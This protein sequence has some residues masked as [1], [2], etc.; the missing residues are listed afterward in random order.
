VPLLC[1]VPTPLRAARVARRLCDAQGGVLFGRQVA[2]PS[3]LVPGLLAEAGERRPLL[4]PLAERLLALEA[5]RAAGALGGEIDPAGGLARSLLATVAEMR[6]GEVTA[7][8]AGAAAEGLEPRPA[9]RLRSL[10]GVLTRYERR[11]EDLGVLDAA[12]GERAAA[13]ALRRG[14]ASAETR[15]LDLLVVEGFHAAAPPTFDL[16]SALAERAAR[17]EVRIPYLPQRPDLC[18]PAESLL[19]RVE[20]MH[21]IAG[22]GVVEVTFPE[23]EA[24]RAPRLSGLL[25][26][27][28]GGGGAQAAGEGTVRAVGGGGEEGEAQAAARLASELLERGL[29]PE[30]L[31]LLAPSPSRAAGPLRR[32]FAERGVPL[33]AGAA[34]RL[35][36]SPPVRAVLLALAAAPRPTREAAEAL[37]SSTYL[38]PVRSAARIAHLL[39]RAGALD[40]RIDPEAALRE[41]AARLTLPSVA[42][43]RAGLLGAAD[44]LA[45]LSAGIRPLAAPGTG[46]EM[47][48]RLR[49]FLAAAGVR[50]R[51]A[52]AEA[53]VARRDLAALTRLEELADS[54]SEALALL[55]RGSERLPPGEWRALVELA[56]GGSG[57]PANPEPAAGAVELWPLSEAPG[58]SAR[59]VIA[60]G[61]ARGD[62]PPPPAPEAWLRDPERGAVNR[63][64]RRAALA[65][66]P[67]RRAESAYLAFSAMAAAREHLAFT[68][69]AAGQADRPAP[70][71]AEALLAAGAEAPE[72]PGDPSLGRAGTAGEALRAAA[73]LAR[74]GRGGE[75]AGALQAAGL[76]AR[77]ASAA[78]RGRIE[79]ERRE[80][81]LGRAPAP[82]AGGIPAE[83]IPELRAALPEEWTPSQLE[84]FA[85][86]PF[87]L[88][89]GEVVGLPEPQAAGLDIDPRDEGRLLH[90]VLERVLA[91]RLARG[92]GPLAGTAEEREEARAA[93]AEVFARFEAEGRVGAPVLWPARRSAL[94]ARLER[95]LAAE[96]RSA[97]GL[98]PRLL[99]HRFGGA[100]GRP[101]LVLRDGDEEVRL[102]GR[103]DRV[104][105]DGERLLVIDYKNGRDPRAA[106]AQL[107]EEALGVTSFQAPAYVMAAA[108]ELPGRRELAASFLLLRPAERTRPAVFG[109]G[110]GFLVAEPVRRAED[111]AAGGSSFADAVVALVRKARG[112][113]F[114]IASRDCSRCGFGAVC[115]FPGAAEG[116]P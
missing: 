91:A 24:G 21:G 87:Q 67:A 50:R 92:Q 84:T 1:L 37:A 11:L 12:A 106:A 34:D 35:A 90:A 100:S 8:A 96:A 13:Q 46:R 26:A 98:A 99:E 116:P 16:L 36:A 39:D 32:A 17:T 108:R 63:L 28:A 54:L 77:A 48:A 38:G 75:A 81:L 10:A 115:R 97:D 101:P 69:A 79:A 111:R 47:A 103:I 72:I 94:L 114:P 45:R 5:G 68:W 23:M 93:A 89:L 56:V 33:S 57:S 20:A 110:D 55:G 25:A 61:C 42:A 2:A 51:A 95:V 78:E 71:A 65:T 27:L 41:R 53:E 85:N 62:W 74:A 44:D 7:A 86:C 40:G 105:A 3:Q 112:G 66:S 49:G 76:G 70:L 80:A 73:R 64:L 19:R 9:E 109:A 29:S 31:L 60:T 22:G 4:T 113:E 30:D 58:L 107:S 59:A 88:F 43:E 104:D 14:A 82:H 83:R 102:R 6:R 52:R 15:R 18:G